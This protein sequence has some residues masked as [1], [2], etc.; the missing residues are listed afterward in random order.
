MGGVGR[1]GAKD[2]ENYE[3]PKGSKMER[4]SLVLADYTRSGER[5]SAGSGAE[6][7]LEGSGAEPR[8]QS[9]FNTFKVSRNT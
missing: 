7:R 6:P 5:R 1:R 4:V 9:K 2:A 3:T 8:L